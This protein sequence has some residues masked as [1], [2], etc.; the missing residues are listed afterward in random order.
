MKRHHENTPEAHLFSLEWEKFIKSGR[1]YVGSVGVL[2]DKNLSCQARVLFHIIS[3][4]SFIKGYC[5]ATNEQLCDHLGLQ[6]TA[7]KKYLRELE[8]AGLTL[9]K[10][11]MTRYGFR[12][13]I[14]LLFDTMEARYM[15]LPEPKEPKGSNH[16]YSNWVNAYD[17]KDQHSESE[18]S[19]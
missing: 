8:K 14:F 4:Y 3:S 12:R 5:H 15:E 6:N 10:K 9:T 1:T 19:D 2:E 16:Q 7:L 17:I 13:R 11:V 18:E